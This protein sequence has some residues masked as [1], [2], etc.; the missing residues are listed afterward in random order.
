V[1]V[2][3]R[4]ASPADAAALAELGRLSFIET[5]GHLY[6]PENLDA[7]LV[8]HNEGKWR[9]EL[10]DPG[11]AIRI[12]EADGRAV[13]YAK[14][15]PPSLPFEPQGRP[16]ELRQFYVLKPWQGAGVAADLMQWVLDEARARDADELYLS[17]FVDNHRARR[18]Y[19]RYGFRF[20]AP[21]TF[22]VGSHEDE[23]HILRLDLKGPS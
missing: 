4:N 12:G 16:I 6:T 21:Y 13:A 14:L 18:F 9:D 11:F 22:M 23:D 20:V 8:G 5:F 7:F 3:F 1:S 15:G 2:A 10:R 17:V 19:E